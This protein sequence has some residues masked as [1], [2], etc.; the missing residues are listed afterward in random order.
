MSLILA[1]LLLALNIFG[2]LLRIWNITEAPINVVPGLD[3]DQ[4]FVDETLQVDKTFIA[5]IDR[6]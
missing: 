1:S 2:G 3:F 4:N 5:D 6:F